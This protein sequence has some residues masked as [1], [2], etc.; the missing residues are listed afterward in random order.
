MTENGIPLAGVI[1]FPVA[2]SRS[3]QLHGYW[4]N[5]YRIRGFYVPMP[6]A[7]EDLEDALATLP[8]LGFRGV[9]VTIPHKVRALQI[10]DIVSDRA[11]LIGAAN[12]LTYQKD[13]KLYADNTDGQGLV[14]DLLRLPGIIL[15]GARICLLGAGGAGGHRARGHD[16][17]RAADDRPGR[18]AGYPWPGCPAMADVSAEGGLAR[19]G[20]S[21][22]IG[23]AR[24]GAFGAARRSR[25]AP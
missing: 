21:A 20:R 7:Q 25:G 3:P 18:Q 23:R 1:G 24:R 13:G 22:S 15:S 11:A 8:K 19:P 17:C 12:T 2:H 14:N 4:L 6:V 16:A 9:N 10:A 5:R